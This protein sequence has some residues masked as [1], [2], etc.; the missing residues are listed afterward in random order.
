MTKTQQCDGLTDRLTNG[1]TDGRTDRVT[2]RVACTRLK[3]LMD[4]HDGI[5]C[6]RFEFEGW[7]LV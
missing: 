3:R 7:D 2:Y 5:T 6:Q 4:F 1:P